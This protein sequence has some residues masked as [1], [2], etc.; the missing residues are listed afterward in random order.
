[1]AP[2]ALEEVPAAQFVQ[3]EEPV[4]ALY[5]PIGHDMQEEDPAVA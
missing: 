2:I 3:A 1:M 5:V 4:V